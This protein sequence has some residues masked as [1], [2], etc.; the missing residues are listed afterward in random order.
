MSGKDVEEIAGSGNLSAGAMDVSAAIAAKVVGGDGNAADHEVDGWIVAC[1][2][3]G[4][5]DAV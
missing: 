3:S 4:A 2:E 1:S 5:V